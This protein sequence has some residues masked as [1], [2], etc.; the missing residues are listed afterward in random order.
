MP[1]SM[2]G[3]WVSRHHAFHVTVT[4]GGILR[5]LGGPGR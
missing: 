1:I 3:D 5:E 4:S 2:R